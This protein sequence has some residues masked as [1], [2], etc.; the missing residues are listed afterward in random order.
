MY[1]SYLPKASMTLRKAI[2]VKCN[3][4]LA[5]GDEKNDHTAAQEMPVKMHFHECIK[6]TQ[7]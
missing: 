5:R 4:S 1:H 3:R 6:Q 2:F 7:N